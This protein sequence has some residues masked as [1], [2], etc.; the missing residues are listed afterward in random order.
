[1]ATTSKR[2]I[3][4]ALVSAIVTTML[5]PTATAAAQADPEPIVVWDGAKA[6]YN[7]STLT[8]KIGDNTYTL[9]LNEMNSAAADGSYVQIG[10]ENAKAAITITAVNDD[11]SITNAFGTDGTVTVIMKYTDLPVSAGSNRALI[12]L[13]DSQKY[14]GGNVGSDNS[15]KIGVSDFQGTG[16]FSWQ[17]GYYSSFA[18][19]NFSATEQTAALTYSSTE[20]TAFYLD[21]V[22][23]STN[24]GLKAAGYTTPC[25][26]ALGGIDTD[27]SNQFFAMTGMKIKAVAV[28]TDTLTVEQIA[29]YKFPS[30][31]PLSDVL[32]S[33]INTKFGDNLD[34]DLHL[35]DGARVTGDTTFVVTNVNFYGEGEF[36]ITPPDGNA[37]KFV[38]KQGTPVIEYS[39]T[40]PTAS[41]SATTFTSNA[42]PKS[43]VTDSSAWNGIISLNDMTVADFTVNDFG[44]AS[45]SVRLSGI[46]GWLRAPNNNFFENVVPVQLVGELTINN[47]NS[48]N[49][50][51]QKRCT[52]FKK[53]SGDGKISATN[54]ATRVVIVI[55]DATEFYGNIDLYNKHIVFGKK[56]PDY[57]V[58]TNV[59]PGTI[60]INQ[61][62]TVTNSAYWKASGGIKVEGELCASGLDRFDSNTIST[63]SDTGVFTLTSI[64]NGS[65]N[66]AQTDYSRI[67]G[68]GTLKYEGTGW[69]AVS[70]S[71]FPTNM[72]VVNEQAG[73]LIL[74]IPDITYEI[75]SLAGSGMFE[76]NY[77][78]LS[79]P[80]YLR[81]LQLKD[82]EWSGLIKTDSQNRFGGLIVASGVSAAGTLT[83]SGTQIQRAQLTVESGAAV[84]L[85]G[86]WKGATAVA[87]TIGGTGTITGDVT[88]SDGSTIKVNDISDLLSVSG[89]LTAN[90]GT[91]TVDLPA[92]TPTDVG[93]VFLNV[94]GQITLGA[95]FNVT[96]DGSPTRLK[97]FKTAA[98]LKAAPIPFSIK[99]R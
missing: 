59:S 34:I 78:N 3:V 86:T 92:G 97:V 90:S 8:K 28:F 89:A 60:F 21:G 16:Y 74:T 71:N 36:I 29:N 26:I 50:S 75:G 39:G 5:I 66:E 20:G 73:N 61:G 83:L 35:A 17:G 87:G 94:E 22:G 85:T 65:A 38:F 77:V 54:D 63:T 79:S 47:G 33:E 69:R 46:T 42:I 68:T 13:L 31:V 19:A 58:I 81:V 48:A 52:V 10:S 76:A 55:K 96:I 80:R 51:N 23:I 43:F 72:T 91:I 14:K 9:N 7:F 62:T 4:T 24:T 41:T 57:S 6:G 53:I 2:V 15:V 37:A 11:T 70:I 84:N 25:G 45:S 30:D 82:T 95:L 40:L 67:T 98:G 12:S 49:D 18:G 32:V 88:L 64:G 56:M 93:T 27:G 1:M 44:N 99:I